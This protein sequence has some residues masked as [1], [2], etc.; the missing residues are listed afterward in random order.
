[1]YPTG[2]VCASQDRDGWD[3]EIWALGLSQSVCELREDR[4]SWGFAERVPFKARRVTSVAHSGPA[5]ASGAANAQAR[6]G[7]TRRGSGRAGGG[8]GTGLRRRLLRPQSPAPWALEVPGR[9]DER[10]PSQGCS[11]GRARLWGLPAGRKGLTGPRAA[12][13][14]ARSASVAGP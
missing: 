10:G 11:L 2:Q 4:A 6:P 5:P 7:G 13:G 9:R 14:C 12:R 8:E 1:M 3:S